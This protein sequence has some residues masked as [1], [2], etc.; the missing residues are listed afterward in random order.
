MKLPP[1]CHSAYKISISENTRCAVKDGFC[2]FSYIN[3]VKPCVHRPYSWFPEIT[4]VQTSV[5]T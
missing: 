3:F 5:C 4:L 1:E 2:K